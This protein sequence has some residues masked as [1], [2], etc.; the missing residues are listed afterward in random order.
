M[1]RRILRVA[2]D[3]G[4][5]IADVKCTLHAHCN[6]NGQLTGQEGICFWESRVPE[7]F[8]EEYDMFVGTATWRGKTAR[9]AWQAV[10]QAN[11]ALDSV[12]R[13]EQE[14]SKRFKPEQKYVLEDRNGVMIKPIRAN[15]PNA[16][17]CSI[18]K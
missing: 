10:R 9:R 16:T 5:Y 4:H 7:L 17:K 12:L 18:S 15:L 3:L 1:L 14:L 11:A 6:Y 2:A 13:F 8:A